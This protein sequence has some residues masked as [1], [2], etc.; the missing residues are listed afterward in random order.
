MICTL[1]LHAGIEQ[2]A[3]AYR[4]DIVLAGAKS[5]PLGL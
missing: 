4:W 2:I 3:I 5:T 1:D